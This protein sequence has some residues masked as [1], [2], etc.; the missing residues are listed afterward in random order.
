MPFD[1]A[2]TPTGERRYGIFDWSPYPLL[3]SM[4]AP[5]R[6]RLFPQVIRS[7]CRPCGPEQASRYRRSR[8]RRA[9]PLAAP[10]G[11]SCGAT[12]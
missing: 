3:G 5:V 12:M 2:E 6:R 4:A 9:T 7:V 10:S 8:D 11:S 1:S